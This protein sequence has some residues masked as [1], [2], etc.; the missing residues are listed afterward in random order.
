MAVFMRVNIWMAIR[1][2]R[3]F[4]KIWKEINMKVISIM[5][6]NIVKGK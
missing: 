2:E 5:G 1:V 3:V 4:S 6:I